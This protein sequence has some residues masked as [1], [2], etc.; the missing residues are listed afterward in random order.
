M[1]KNYQT[2]LGYLIIG[3]A[4]VIAANILGDRLR[5]GL[6]MLRDGVGTLGDRLYSAPLFQGQ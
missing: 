6:A 2:L 4:I 5:E 3:I 1:L